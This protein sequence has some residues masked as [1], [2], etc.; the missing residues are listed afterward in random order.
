MPVY[1]SVRSIALYR[2]KGVQITIF[3]NHKIR[4][5]NGLHDVPEWH[6]NIEGAAGLAGGGS[7]ARY[8][9]DG[10]KPDR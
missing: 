10:L 7:G 2:P 5:F 8:K 6:R 4:L 9:M 1:W 3:F